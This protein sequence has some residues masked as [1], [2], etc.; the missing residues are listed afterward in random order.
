[1]GDT[2][3]SATV[4]VLP[5]LQAG[6]HVSAD[7]T[8]A[9]ADGVEALAQG[10]LPRKVPQEVRQALAKASP[11]LDNAAVVLDAA[12]NA[13][14]S[15]EAFVNYVAGKAMPVARA[16]LAA[17]SEVV[18]D[19]AKV[20]LPESVPLPEASQ[21]KGALQYFGVDTDELGAAARVQA[22]TT[23]AELTAKLPDPSKLASDVLRDALGD[24][25]MPPAKVSP[26][27]P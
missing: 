4:K 23:T 18:A 10:P 25:V 20:P 26:K 27:A 17:V 9:A 19:A 3:Q 1:V 7:A 11:A 14:P 2:L 13:A 21:V 6:V 16:V 22:A 15:A 8:R 24:P 12:A 5:T